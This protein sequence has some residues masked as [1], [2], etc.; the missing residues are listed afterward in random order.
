VNPLLI[1]ILIELWY[2][3]YTTIQKEFRMNEKPLLIEGLENLYTVNE[4]GWIFSIRQNRYLSM[5]AKANH[6]DPKDCYS[7]TTVQVEG[8]RQ[9][10]LTHRAIA[11]AYIPNPDNLPQVNHKDSNK[12]NNSIDNL[13]W[14]SNSENQLHSYRTTDRTPVSG[15]KHGRFIPIG[16]FDA[17][18]NLLIEFETSSQALEITGI[19]PTS[20]ARRRN[21][22][23]PINAI[24]HYIKRL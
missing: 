5:Q 15:K 6:N 14:V 24:G 10:I 22:N 20:F 9:Q 23:K 1:H 18:D 11:L 16:L 12:L 17:E 8:K 4:N 19:P 13:E 7:T 21:D 3:T 2:N